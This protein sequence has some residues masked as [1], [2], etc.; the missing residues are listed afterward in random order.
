MI[1]TLSQAREAREHGFNLGIEIDSGAGIGS[2]LQILPNC[3][4]REYLPSFR[5]EN[6]ADAGPGVCRKIVDPFVREPNLPG[7]FWRLQAC[8]RTHQRGLSGAVCAK[9]RDGFPVRDNDVDV[10]ESL[11]ETVICVKL[12]DL[13]HRFSSDL[14]RWTMLLFFRRGVT[15]ISFPDQRIVPDFCRLADGD[16]LAA[17]EHDDVVAQR[18]DH[19][20]VVLNN[21]D[22]DA[23]IRDTAQQC[24][25]TLLVAFRQARG[26][27]IQQQNL[28][29][30]CQR[31]R[32][33]D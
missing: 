19:R 4:F 7:G 8:N 13:E 24:C 21:D 31:A 5:Y 15:E 12:L 32:N 14:A 3:Q 29:A 30:Q 28:G 23:Q 1:D 27:F 17:V 18:H 33:L 9:D 22:R 26:R 16:S 25:E 2:Q 6:Y 11:R 10:F 20:H